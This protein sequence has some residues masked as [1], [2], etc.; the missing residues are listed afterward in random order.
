[1]NRLEQSALLLELSACLST[2]ETNDGAT[3]ATAIVVG[4]DSTCSDLTL[5][6]AG[7]PPPL[8]Y[9]AAHRQW[10]LLQKPDSLHPADRLACRLA[11]GSAIHTRTSS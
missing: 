7:H 2:M 10:E 1:M 4:F 3:Y 5:T 9:R 6:N 8:W 11:W